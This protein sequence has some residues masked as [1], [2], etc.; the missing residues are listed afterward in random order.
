MLPRLDGSLRGQRV[1]LTGASAAK[2]PDNPQVQYHL[3]M[4][5]VKLGDKERAEKVLALAL[6]SPESFRGKEERGRRCRGFGE[7]S[8]R[9]SRPSRCRPD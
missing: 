9:R 4:V 5:Y 1:L 3:G 7:V 2:L 6:G 8:R